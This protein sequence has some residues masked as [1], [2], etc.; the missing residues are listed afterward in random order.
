MLVKYSRT[1]IK[2]LTLANGHGRCTAARTERTPVLIVLR[3]P[4]LI[5]TASCW[6]CLTALCDGRLPL[7]VTAAAFAAARFLCVP[8]ELSPPWALCLRPLFVA[9]WELHLPQPP[10]CQCVALCSCRATALCC[11]WCRAPRGTP[12]SQRPTTAP[13][14]V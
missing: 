4:A 14:V 13:L 8:S 6:L 5:M 3:R 7:S 1:K 10:F 12:L 2:P 11:A 9:R